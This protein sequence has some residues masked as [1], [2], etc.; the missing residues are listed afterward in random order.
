MGRYNIKKYALREHADCPSCGEPQ[1]LDFHHWSYAASDSIIESAE[2]SGIHLCRSCHN[3]VHGGRWSPNNFR[4]K[5]SP[6]NRSEQQAWATWWSKNGVKFR[7]WRDLAF[8]NTVDLYSRI[9]R[10]SPKDPRGSAQHIVELYKIPQPFHNRLEIIVSFVA[11]YH[12][13]LEEGDDHS[14]ATARAGL[15][16]L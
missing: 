16:I 11:R 8:S 1:Y 10:S 5:A 9:N 3:Y 4:T 15:A 12:Q 2:E 13:C 7:D 6:V 14:I